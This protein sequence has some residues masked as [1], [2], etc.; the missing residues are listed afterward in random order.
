MSKIWEYKSNED[1]KLAKKVEKDKS[2]VMTN[3]VMAKYIIDNIT[4]EQGEK[5]LEPCKGDG[6]FYDN[7]PAN[8]IKGWCEINEGRD[9]LTY[10]DVEVDTIISNPPFVPRKLFWSFQMKAM[11]ICKNRIFWLINLSSLN[12]FTPKRL[13]EMK[14]LNWFIQKFTIVNDKRWFGRYVVIEMGRTNLG[15]FNWNRQ[16]F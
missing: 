12:V 2:I 9:F 11:D 10:D 6:A 16:S 1:D 8:V 7:L 13:D 4:W 3:P 14:A 15:F 5:V